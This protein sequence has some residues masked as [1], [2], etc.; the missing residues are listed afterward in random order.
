MALNEMQPAVSLIPQMT[1]TEKKVNAINSMLSA[2]A[3]LSPDNSTH[4]TLAAIQTNR[5]MTTEEFFNMAD[6]IKT[7]FPELNVMIQTIADSDIEAIEGY[8]PQ[9][10]VQSK[11]RYIP[12]ITNE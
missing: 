9:I 8:Y 3:S 11:L 7:S 5:V 10:N 2:F 6:Q 1:E 4:L 12:T